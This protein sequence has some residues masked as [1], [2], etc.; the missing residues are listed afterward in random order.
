M[1]DLFTTM[2]DTFQPLRGL[3]GLQSRGPSRLGARRLRRHHAGLARATARRPK[4]DR[5][6]FAVRPDPE[7]AAEIA[8]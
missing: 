1:D 2:S 4:T 6:F 5:L 7:T 3:P 8:E